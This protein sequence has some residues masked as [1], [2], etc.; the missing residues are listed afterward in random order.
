MRQLP[1]RARSAQYA[2]RAE[3]RARRAPDAV[4]HRSHQVYRP[5]QRHDAVLSGPAVGKVHHCRHLIIKNPAMKIVRGFRWTVAVLSV[6]L[7]GGC[8]SAEQGSRA[9]L[10]SAAGKAAEVPTQFKVL[11][12]SLKH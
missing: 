1:R 7:S 11:E 6:M 10:S 3:F 2:G 5:R 9:A 8:G 4:G 12:Q